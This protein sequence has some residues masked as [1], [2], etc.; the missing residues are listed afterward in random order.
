MLELSYKRILSI[1]LPLMFGTFVQSLIAITDGAFVSKLGNTAYNAVGNGSIMYVILFMVCR[2]LADGTQITIAKKYGEDKLSEIGKTLFNAQFLQL[3]LAAFLFV[4]FILFSE[5]VI[6]NI[7]KSEAIGSAMVQFIKYRSWGIFFAALQV[8]MVAYFI[9]I[10]R[11]RII[12]YSTLVLAL[13]NILLDYCLIFGNFGFPQLDM[14]GAPVASSI[15]EAI[16]FLFLLMYALKAK[17]LKKFAFSLKLKIERSKI[18]FPLI[19]LSFP[20]ML[21]GMLSLLTWWIFFSMVEHMGPNDLEVAHNIRY[22]YFLAFIPIFGFAAATKTYVSNLVGRKELHLI[23]KIQLKIMLLAVAGTF[24]LFHGAFFYPELLIRIVEHNPDV[25]PE[26]IQ[27]SVDSL[28]FV[29]GSILV[30][31]I[32]VV[33]FHSVA[34]LG[35]TKLSFAI[36]C[37]AITIYLIACYFI[38]NQWQWSIIEVW[39]IEYIYFGTLGIISILYLI[40]FNKRHVSNR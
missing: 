28:R 15:A 21:Q 37:I 7:A 24:L 10:G 20:L 26:I 11:T 13:S 9:G 2:G 19:K 30:F 6:N 17:S 40:Y 38:I 39:W 31:A 8:T 3:I 27:N 33:P 34:A 1:A 25:S 12:I 4:F 29:S 14:I 32:S 16:T 23:P 35:K 5:S 36:E 22:M 18:I